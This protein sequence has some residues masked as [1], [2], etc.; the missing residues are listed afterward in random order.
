MELT[1]IPKNDSLLG[2]FRNDPGVQKLIRFS[3]DYYCI[4]QN[5]SAGIDFHDMRF[6]QVGGWDNPYAGFVFSYNI[7]KNAQQKANINQGRFEASTGE[8]FHSL[9][10]RIKGIH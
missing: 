8:A 1:F 5:D 4:T 2:D 3:Q 6:G 9:V 7:T 10:R